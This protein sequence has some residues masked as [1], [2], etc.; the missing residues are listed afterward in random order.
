L[1]LLK[2]VLWSALGIEPGSSP[3]IHFKVRYNI[4]LAKI[5]KLVV[6]KEM[7]LKNKTTRMIKQFKESFSTSLPQ[8]SIG[9]GSFFNK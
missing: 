9:L 7:K 5:F 3:L 4:L 2:T 1:K 8:F 6:D